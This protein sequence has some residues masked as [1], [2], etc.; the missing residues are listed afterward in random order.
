MTRDTHVYETQE[1]LYERMS[2]AMAFWGGVKIDMS[3]AWHGYLA[4]GLPVQDSR[5]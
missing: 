2:M 1:A 3:V 5:C 4:F